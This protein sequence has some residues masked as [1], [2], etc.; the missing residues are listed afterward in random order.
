LTVTDVRTGKDVTMGSDNTVFFGAVTGVAKTWLD[1]K[2]RRLAHL[3]GSA[4]A[5][6]K[7]RQ[8][9]TAAKPKP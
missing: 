2:E 8:H 6:K 3:R 5:A 9:G 4:K 1:R 7:A